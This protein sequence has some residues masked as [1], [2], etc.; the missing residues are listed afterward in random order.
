MNVQNPFHLVQLALAWSWWPTLTW[1][2]TQMG[3]S[4]QRGL[5]S[6]GQPRGCTAG[7]PARPSV[8]VG[9]GFVLAVLQ[10]A[11]VQ[12][13]CHPHPSP[14]PS[15]ATAET[16]PLTSRGQAPPTASPSQ[17]TVPTTVC[18]RGYWLLS[19]AVCPA[20]PPA[21]CAVSSLTSSVSC[22]Q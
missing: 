22:S 2:I 14:R 17:N 13:A 7:V 12:L 19:R 18:H 4:V 10:C 15:A 11:A 16:D 9:G 8:P 6:C 1:H 3:R 5:P 20:P 21:D